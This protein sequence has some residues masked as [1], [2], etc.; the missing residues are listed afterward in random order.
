M[1]EVELADNLKNE[2]NGP[3]VFHRNLPIVG[4]ECAELDTLD[5]LVFVKK[6]SF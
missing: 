1:L 3:I 4:P 6:H 5:L 2:M